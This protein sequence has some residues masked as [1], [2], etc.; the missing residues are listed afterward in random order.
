MEH[1]RQYCMMHSV[2]E[3]EA[4]SVPYFFEV[5][6]AM[7]RMCASIIVVVVTIVNIMKYGKS[8]VISFEKEILTLCAVKQSSAWKDLVQYSAL[9][10]IIFTN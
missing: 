2:L 9:G 10:Y 6:S 1:A 8:R 7:D 3:A 5:D 4:W